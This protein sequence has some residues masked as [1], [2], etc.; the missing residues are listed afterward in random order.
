[1]QTSEQA[2]ISFFERVAQKDK[3]QLK[4]LREEQ[5]F[6]VEQRCWLFSIPDLYSFLQFHDDVFRCLNYTQF[7][8]LIFNAPIHKGVKSFG[9]EII[10]ADNQ[11]KVDKS[12]YALVWDQ[13]F[14][15]IVN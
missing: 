2:L 10:I 6:S 15:D 9:A 1:M 5:R 12:E 4:R 7:R 13:S 8:Q 14:S 3:K 11:G